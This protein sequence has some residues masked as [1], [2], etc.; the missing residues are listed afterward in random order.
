M[1]KNFY[2]KTL[3]ISPHSDDEI[4]ALPFIYSLDNEF[5]SIDLLLVECDFKR[6]EEAKLSAK[7]HKFN[8]LVM[9]FEYNLK[10]LEFHKKIPLLVSYLKKIWNSY[11]LVLSPLIEGGHQDHDSISAALLLSKEKVYT[12]S[13]VIFY[14]TYSNFQFLPIL[15]TCRVSKRKFSKYIFKVN[16]ERKKLIIL[17]LRT[18]YFCYKSQWKSW[19]L[20]FPSILVGFINSDIRNFVVADQFNFDDIYWIASKKPLYEIYRGLSFKKWLTFFEEFN[21][22]LKIKK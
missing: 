7:M 11:D 4:F 19:I 14:A 12:K 3:I 2:K 16:F 10:G 13:K 22:K 21:N 17:Y 18:I 9:P 15:Y 20:L 8:L 1:H 6:Y 5:K